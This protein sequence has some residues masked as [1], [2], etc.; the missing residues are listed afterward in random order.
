MKSRDGN[1]NPKSVIYIADSALLIFMTTGKMMNSTSFFVS[2]HQLFMP[3]FCGILRDNSNAAWKFVGLPSL[4]VRL[5]QVQAYSHTL[6][7][8]IRIVY[9]L[10]FLNSTEFHF[11]WWFFATSLCKFFTCFKCP[12]FK[13]SFHKSYNYL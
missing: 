5:N 7:Y 3:F 13:I 6:C 4:M 1:P 8:C 2:S 9:F 11:A 10:T 12:Y